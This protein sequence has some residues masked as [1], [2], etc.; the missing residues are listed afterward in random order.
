MAL[1][2]KLKG[3]TGGRP[4]V[5]RQ[6]R[7]GAGTGGISQGRCAPHDAAKTFQKSRA[8]ILRGTSNPQYSAEG[9]NPNSSTGDATGQH[10][11]DAPPRRSACACGTYEPTPVLREETPALL[12]SAY[13]CFRS[14][15]GVRADHTRDCRALWNNLRGAWRQNT[16]GSRQAT[17]YFHKRVGSNLEHTTE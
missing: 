11:L 6:R 12:I 2:G 9:H 1:A 14:A 15:Q 4:A 17:A 8:W 7:G 3:P 16:A 5:R 10:G 13:E